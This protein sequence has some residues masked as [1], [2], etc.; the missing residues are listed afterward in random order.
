MERNLTND[1]LILLGR[2]DL[3]IVCISLVDNLYLLIAGG[4]GSGLSIIRW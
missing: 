4:E 3:I 1:G 2:F